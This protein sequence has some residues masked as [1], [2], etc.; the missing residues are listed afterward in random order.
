MRIFGDSIKTKVVLGFGLALSI[1]VFGVYLTYSSFTQLLTSVEVLSHPNN[2]LAKLQHTL[3]NMSTAES[4]IRA[5]TLTT[6]EEHFRSYLSHLDTI[7][8]QID[9]LRLMMRNSPQEL[10][11]A[12]SISSLLE[13]KQASLERYVALKKQQQERNFSGKA[14]QEIASTAREQPLPTVTTIKQRTTTTITDRLSVHY[15]DTLQE[16]KASKSKESKGLFSKIFSKRDKRNDGQ[17]ISPPPPVLIP[18]LS[19]KEE[20]QV[21]TSANVAQVAPLSKVRR[22]LHDVQREAERSQEELIAK[23][24]ALLQQDKNIMDQIRNMVHKLE[25]H[26]ANLVAINSA[27][28]RHVAKQTAMIMLIVG[29]AGLGGGIAFILLILRDITRSNSYKLQLIKARKEAVQLARAKEAFVANMS[30][31]IR[32]PLN[33]VLGFS[34]QLSHTQLQQGQQ[35]YLQAI[36][37]AGSHLLH[38]VNDVLDLSKI[39]A[40]KLHIDYTSFNLHQ[41]IQEIEEAFKLKATSKGIQLLCKADKALPTVLNGDPMRLKQ[42]LFNLVDNAIKFTD[43]GQVQVHCTIRSKRRNRIVVAIEVADTGVGIPLE[44]TEHIFGEFNQ[45]DESIIRRYG[46]TGLGLSISKKL[47]EMQQGTLS[48]QSTPGQGTTFTIILPLYKTFSESSLAPERTLTIPED[49]VQEQQVLQDKRILVIDDDGYSRTLCEIILKRWGMHVQLA[50]DG[51]TALKAIEQ[52]HFDLVL[53]DIQ[54]PGMSGKAVSKAIRRKNAT[55][56]IIALTAN[57]LS[58]NSSFFEKTGISDYLLKPFT[59]QELQQK[60]TKALQRATITV[61]PEQAITNPLFVSCKAAALYDLSEMKT[62]TGPDKE[63]LAAV[64]EVLLTDHRQN[65]QQLKAAVTT[66]D[67]SQAGNLAHKM[68]TA[69]KHLHAHTVTPALEQLEQLLHQEIFETAHL[70]ALVAQLEAHL[71]QVLNALEQELNSLRATAGAV[72]Q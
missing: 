70:P 13:E 27:K 10:A 5:Y 65:F 38:I 22:I 35:Q 11:Q 47:I 57:V 49:N 31:E 7:K 50:A 63:A 46:G 24:L 48:L 23:E 41:L 66:E 6:K 4:S 69:F 25:R 55:L 2:K 3:E 72:I 14:M 56:P 15:G 34:E 16:Q 52:Q 17:L 33:V 51:P 1:V 28:A 58:R 30:H 68:L 12:D 67:W 42:V 62:F 64:I 36:Q 20:V 53:T 40:G 60:I 18:E 8:S 61:K 9:S 21:D 45:A 54:L 29:I 19:V 59:E 44:R 37:N 43:K 71:T 39:E 26:E 32:T